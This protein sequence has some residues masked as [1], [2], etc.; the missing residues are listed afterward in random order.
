MRRATTVW[1]WLAAAGLLG[2]VT[3]LASSCS[4]EVPRDEATGTVPRHHPS[5]AGFGVGCDCAVE[6][7]RFCGVCGATDECICCEASSYCPIDPCDVECSETPVSF[8]CP[9]GYP[10]D[11]GDGTC[12][13]KDHPS[14]CPQGMC[15]PLN[16]IGCD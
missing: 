14:C 12:C 15:G 1:T 3:L 6:D 8:V 10:N 13:P 9:S 2:A 7:E 11:C 5:G 16:E 4:G